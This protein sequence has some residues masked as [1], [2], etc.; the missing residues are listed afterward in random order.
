MTLTESK[1]AAGAALRRPGRPLAPCGW[2]CTTASGSGSRRESDSTLVKPSHPARVALQ[3]TPPRVTSPLLRHFAGPAPARDSAPV[4]PLACRPWRLPLLHLRYWLH[5]CRVA[6]R[7]AVDALLPPYEPYQG[8][9]GLYARPWAAGWLIRRQAMALVVPTSGAVGVA[10]Q[11]A[12]PC[13][14]LVALLRLPSCISISTQHEVTRAG[15]KN[16][17]I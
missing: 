8:Y 12:R 14:S 6:P 7:A 5:A 15:N 9:C 4:P 1:G 16:W 13:D 10:S 2:S 17:L 3:G 11:T